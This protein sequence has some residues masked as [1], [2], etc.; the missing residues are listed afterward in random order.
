[1]FG[2]QKKRLHGKGFCN[3]DFLLAVRGLG[4]MAFGLGNME[5]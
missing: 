3:F 2:P 5:Y 4:C 1:M